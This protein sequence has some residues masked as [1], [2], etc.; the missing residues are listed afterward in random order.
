MILELT[1]LR[2]G[3]S[4]QDKPQPLSL[5]AVHCQRCAAVLEHTL[6]QCCVTGQR[7]EVERHVLLV[8]A[9]FFQGFDVQPQRVRARQPTERVSSD[10]YA[11][12]DLLEKV[13]QRAG[14]RLEEVAKLVVCVLENV[15]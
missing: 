15:G 5:R 8:D 4:A 10:A 13:H 14:T 1:R 3:A 6:K 11:R 7:F 2:D 12:R 9:G